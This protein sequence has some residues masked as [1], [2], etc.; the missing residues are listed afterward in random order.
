M[1]EAWHAAAW[2]LIATLGAG[3]SALVLAAYGRGEVIY[4]D[5]LTQFLAGCAL[6]AAMIA[7]LK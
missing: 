3:F 4:I 7:V 6:I 2:L 5:R 1:I